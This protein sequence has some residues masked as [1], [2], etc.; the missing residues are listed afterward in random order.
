MNLLN[1]LLKS[2]LSESSIS[3]LAKKTGLKSAALKKLIQLALPLLIKFMT[4]N[5]SSQSGA[6]SLLSA[7]GQHTNNRS[8]SDQI[9]DAD[10]EDGSKI[11]GHIFGDQTDAIE[12]TLALQSGLSVADV[13]NAL[14][15]LAPAVLSSLNT[16]TASVSSTPKFDL[17]DGFDLSDVAGLVGLAQSGAQTG[18][19]G[20]GLLSGLFGGG[21][22]S[23]GGGLL[24]A[25]L[26]SSAQQAE[27]DTSVN[28]NQL[29][30]LLASLK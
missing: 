6:L 8:L 10:L 30:S 11:L 14:S 7:L 21:S 22:A 5:A 4:N 19:A 23:L 20:S 28:G 24:D 12:N 3:A 17:S 13:N 25:F 18:A 2:L 15:G 16:A 29:L 27:S 1:L 26:G 9:D